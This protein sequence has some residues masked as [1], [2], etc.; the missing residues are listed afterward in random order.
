MSKR[1]VITKPGKSFE[2]ALQH[3]EVLDDDRGLE[4][5]VLQDGEV[6]VKVKATC[7]NFPDL[8][9]TT[10]GYQHKQEFPY[11][12]GLEVSGVISRV[13]PNVRTPQLE[14][15]VSVMIM[16]KGLGLA[17]YIVVNEAQCMVMP[18]PLSYAEGAAY[19][20]GYE[21]AFHSLVERGLIQVDDVVLVSGATGG[22][23]LAAAQ[24]AKK[25]FGCT[26][27]AAGGAD[28][29]LE[30]VKQVSG[31]DHVINY[32]KDPKFS[33]RVKEL[34][35]GKGA[36]LVFDTVGGEVF[37]Q[38]LRST[39]FGARVL[40]VGFTSGE[41]PKVPTNYVLIKCLSIIG[42][43]AGEV[44]LRIPDATNLI[45]G[46]RRIRL[47]QYGN[48]GW[49]KS[50][51]SHTFPFTTEGVRDA[52]RALMNR[53]VVGRVCVVQDDSKSSF[54]SSAVRAAKL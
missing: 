41:R 31:A 49:L 37:Q 54:S 21:T 19:R 27:I 23:G 25:V 40:I 20:M 39:A 42:C 44:L 46:P 1:A 30:T 29:K 15:G 6:L 4:S 48:K 10:N 52:Y 53:Q 2:D 16:T 32:N 18:S 26:V 14:E 9:Q 47:T 17:S 36:T 35:N 43:R 38:A 45:S 24:L 13:G 34:T 33:Q 8:L 3:L 22:M 50:H 28:D 5:Q 51:V 11:T 12:P 7:I